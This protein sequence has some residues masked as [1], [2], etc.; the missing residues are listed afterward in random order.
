MAGKKLIMKNSVFQSS[1]HCTVKYCTYSLLVH[2]Y[3]KSTLSMSGLFM[4]TEV[5]YK[6][7]IFIISVKCLQL[8]GGLIETLQGFAREASASRR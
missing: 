2:Y 8:R 7:E 1:V 3:T 6:S 4:C 5:I